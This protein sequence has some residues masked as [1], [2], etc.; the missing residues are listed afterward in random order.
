MV[1]DKTGNVG[2]GT[3]SPDTNVKLQVVGDIVGKAQVFK[4]YMTADFSKA[5]SWEKLPFNA[6]SYNTL[7]GTF[8]TTNNRF[9]ASRAGYYQVNTAGYSPTAS[10]G[11]DRYGMAIHVNGAPVEITGGN[12]SVGDTPLVPLTGIVYLNGT[13]DYVEIYM[14][15]VI[16]STMRGGNGMYGVHWYMNYLGN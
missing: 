2:I 4:A 5:A 13:T 15:S 9:T 3:T 10:A 1:I 7:Q 6:T 12:Y 11:N 8:D 16:I 14:Y